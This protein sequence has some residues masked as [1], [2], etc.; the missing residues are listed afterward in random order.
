MQLASLLLKF[1]CSRPRKNI[2]LIIILLPLVFISACSSLFFYPQKAHRDN[3]HLRQ[4]SYTDVY[5]PTSDGLLLHAWYLKGQT[6]KKGTVLFLHGNA[7]NISTHINNVLWLTECG[8]DVFAFDY[9]GYGKSAGHPTIEGVHIDAQAAIETI[10][11]LTQKDDERVI[12]LGQ[13]LGGAIAVYATV[14]SPHK[15]RIKALIVDSAFSDYK[16]IAREKLALFTITRLFQYPLASLFADEHS[17]IAWIKR[18]APVPVLF[19]HGDKDTTVPLH[20]S[21]ALFNEAL[22]PKDFWPVKGVGH[23]QS[24]ASKEIREHLLEYLQ[25]I[26]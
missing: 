18:V 6:A 16:V 4:M 21:L 5:F 7:E 20:H 24:L 10:I 19:L 12:I 9:R 15:N 26:K 1:G 8:Y 25:A 13:S 23:I 2:T 11:N 22:P 14:N 17:P 3:Q